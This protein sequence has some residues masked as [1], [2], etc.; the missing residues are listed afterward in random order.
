VK[1]RRIIIAGG[2]TG[3]HIFPALSIA[4]ALRA[5]EPDVD[6][7]FVGAKGRMEMEKVPEA[8]FPIEGLDIAGFDRQA[9]WK[10]I[11]LPLRLLQSFRQ[12]KGITARFRPQAVV[13]VGG[14]S[15]FPML[16]YAQSKGI[17][18]FIHES[19]S[20]A[21]KSNILLGRRATRVFTATE[22]MERYFP[23][24]RITV[25]GNPVRRDIAQSS[26]SREE[27]IRHFGLDPAKT[28][29]LSMGGSLGAKSINE[30]VEAGLE[31]LASKGLQLI[32]QTGKAFA[33]RAAASASGMTGVW[34]SAFIREMPLAYAAADLVVSRSGA[35][36]VTEISVVAKP[37]VLVPYP[38]AAEDHQTFNARTLSDRGAAV[39][40]PDA[41]AAE[42][43]VAEV[44]SLAMD[45]ERRR[46]MGR[47][48]GSGAVRDADVR[49]AGWI[50]AEM[51]KRNERTQRS[52]P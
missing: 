22:G 47:L 14:Y 12:V 2:G 52:E 8:G 11:T 31:T 37:S 32:W 33:S 21:G 10:N 42:R 19:N 50:L 16:R 35:M 7:L 41:Q 49:I 25:T 3:G 18:T 24:D 34:T 46:E 29:I 28:T 39:F 30:S 9:L 38:L 1:R 43:L 17:P 40:V 23:A 27:G 51:D 45:G 20:F 5:A 6:I 36:S 15:S 13:G 44:V 26:L 48:A 4:H